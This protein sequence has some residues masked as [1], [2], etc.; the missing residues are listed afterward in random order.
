MVNTKHN[1]AKIKKMQAGMKQSIQQIGT[2]AWNTTLMMPLQSSGTPHRGT[3][4]V[5][6]GGTGACGNTAP[7]EDRHQ[8]KR[9]FKRVLTSV[10]KIRVKSAR[11]IHLATHVEGGLIQLRKGEK[12]KEGEK[13]QDIP[14]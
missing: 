9:Y 12:G 1:K 6:Q 5:P 10:N 11:S 4:A 8:L 2:G 3:A 7:R 14:N 13:G